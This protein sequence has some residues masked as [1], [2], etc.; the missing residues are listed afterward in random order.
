MSAGAR[1]ERGLISGINVTPMVDVMLVLLVIFMVTARLVMTPA[2][3]LDLPEAHSVEAPQRPL[4]LV[5][6]ASG[7]LTLERRAVDEAELVRAVRAR[8]A[9]DPL[10]RVVIFAAESVPH[11][12]ILHALDLLKQADAHR[13]AFA[14][15]PLGGEP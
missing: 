2:V 10:T 15:E 9:E 13:I 12:R 1:D 11:G 7:A 4:E 14:A 8:I 6:E 5:V 3:A